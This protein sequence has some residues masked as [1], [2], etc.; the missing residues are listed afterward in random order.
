MRASRVVFATALLCFAGYACFY[1][2]RLANPLWSDVEFTG[3]VSPIAHRMAQGARIYSDFT[4][5]IPPASFALMA[6]IQKLLGR[7]LL[8]DELWLCALSQMAMVPIGYW[9]V[10]PYTTARNATLASLMMI[11]ALV[12]SPKEIAY[13]HTT[14]V[15]AWGALACVGQ[16]LAAEA[17]RQRVWLAAGGFVAGWSLAFKSSTGLGAVGGVLAALLVVTLL[18]WRREGWHALRGWRQAWAS[19][20]AGLAGGV[21]ATAGLV[22][23]LGGS[24]F[25]F[26]QTV[27]VDGPALK[28]GRGQAI[29]NLVSYTIL[30]TPT[31]FSLLTATLLAYA[32]ARALARSKRLEVDDTGD[33]AEEQAERGKA[34]LWFAVP[35]SL[36][37]AL[38]FGVATLLLAGNA[39]RVPTVLQIG[40]GFGAAVPMIGLFALVLLMVVNGTNAHTSRDVRARFAAITV[41]AG[42]VSLMHNLSDP[43]HRPLYDN[44]PIIPLAMA[45][46]LIL[47]DQARSRAL[48]YAMVSLALLAVFG[49]KYQRYL[50]ARTPVTEPG[51]WQG[52]RVSANALVLLNAAKRAR[53]LA[54]PHGTVLVLPEDPMFASVI[55][56][57]RPPLF[58]A[59]VFVDQFP[60]HAFARDMAKLRE[61]PPDVLVLHPNDAT[62]RNAVYGIWSL[63]SPAARLQDGL[64]QN[65]HHD[66]YRVD[67]TY[68]TWLFQGPREMEILVKKER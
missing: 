31:S 44:N 65:G 10:R 57:P 64:Q 47:V 29:A 33:P 35:M 5:P 8:L 34:G 55:D 7:F 49:G 63:N 41:A 53:E 9:L 30:Q 24:L 17:G 16:G 46:L 22:L 19:I 32:V 21:A 28:G 58:G 26:Y 13:D 67:S 39:N 36:Y 37:L 27:F 51:F 18:A 54:G 23:A 62:S 6:G 50:E 15:L 68:P 40:A 45:A 38:V 2:P 4:L 11:P 48:K 1:V 12:A 56:R 60:E 59:I 43:K 20:S 14:L 66:L 42:V 3:W 61:N 52:L 25:E